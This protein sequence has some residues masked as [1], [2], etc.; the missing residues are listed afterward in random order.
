MG[1]KVMVAVY[2][3]LI[4]TGLLLVI[5]WGMSAAGSR[6]IGSN[7]GARARKH[8]HKFDRRTGVA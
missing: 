7:Q 1:D 4:I 2:F 5:M 8:S 3:P 6:P